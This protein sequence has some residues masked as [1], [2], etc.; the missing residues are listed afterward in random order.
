MVVRRHSLREVA[1]HKTDRTFHVNIAESGRA[2]WWTLAAF[3]FLIPVLEFV[4]TT[5]RALASAGGTSLA[6]NP[7]VLEWPI[8]SQSTK[9]T[10]LWA[11]RAC[12]GQAPALDVEGK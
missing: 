8:N 4:A 11:D 5:P 9:S 2:G 6:L 3:G 7:E 1:F 10:S 12:R